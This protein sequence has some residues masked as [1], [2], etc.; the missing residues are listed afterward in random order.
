MPTSALAT[1]V[2]TVVLLDKR[3]L[4]F[5]PGILRVP[6]D[7]RALNGDLGSFRVVDEVFLVATISSSLTFLVNCFLTTSV[8]IVVPDF[9]LLN[10]GCDYCSTLSLDMVN[11]FFIGLG[12]SDALA[13]GVIRALWSCRGFMHWSYVSIVSHPGIEFLPGTAP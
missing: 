12:A 4:E 7:L 1:T 3:P 13:V 2:P 5:I 8:F 6:Y 10:S 9:T 11:A